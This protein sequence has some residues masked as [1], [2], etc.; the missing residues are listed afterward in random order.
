MFTLRSLFVNATSIET[1]RRFPIFTAYFI[2][3]LAISPLLSTFGGVPGAIHRAYIILGGGG[4][5]K[6]KIGLTLYLHG[7]GETARVDISEGFFVFVCV[8]VCAC[9]WGWGGVVLQ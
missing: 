1:A 9:V 4:S 8:C 5:G 2:P 7:E 3:V 6:G